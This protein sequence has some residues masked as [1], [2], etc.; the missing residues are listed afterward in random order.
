MTFYGLQP[1]SLKFNLIQSLKTSVPS[2]AKL[3]AVTDSDLQH[4]YNINNA[5]VRL[6][7]LKGIKNWSNTV[8]VASTFSMHYNIFEYYITFK[9]IA[10]RFEYSHDPRTD[11]SLPNYG[12]SPRRASL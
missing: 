4:K 3:L 1:G 9:N 8:A 12:T 2:F 5:D 11:D 10:F 7:I 6:L